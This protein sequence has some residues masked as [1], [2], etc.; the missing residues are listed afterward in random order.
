MA[1]VTLAMLVLLLT[2]APQ[3]PAP[4]GDP[5][6]IACRFESHGRSGAHDDPT[7]HPLLFWRQAGRV[8][9][10]DVAAGTGELWL[11]DAEG[12]LT[13][14]RLFHEDRRVIEHV[15]AD[16]AILD[17]T[18]AWPRVASLVDEG[19]LARLTDRG[20]RRAMGW[21]ARLY[22]GE[23]DGIRTEVT[24][25]PELSVPARIVRHLP[26]GR[27]KL[28]LA[29]THAIEDAPFAPPDS[30]SYEV[31]DFADIGDKENDPFLQR[32][33]ARDGHQH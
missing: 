31:I 19:V 26:S 18:D 20:G 9:V 8:E 11:R 33:L 32:V 21:A 1:T 28:V 5:P 4:A 7:P 3:G 12:R 10:Q 16:L 2:P 23:I 15:S 27:Q 29:E 14:M 17:R 24:W 30:S 25:I 6:A 13:W 22:S